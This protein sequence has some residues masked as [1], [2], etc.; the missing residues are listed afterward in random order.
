VIDR[1]TYLLLQDVIRREGRSFLQYAAES[2]PWST[3]EEQSKA[4]Q[5]KQLVSEERESA[6]ALSR[7]LVKH[8]LTP[9]YLGAY[10]S[11]FTSYNYLSLDRLIPLLVEHQK[12]G[13]A[14]L[15]TDLN[16]LHDGETHQQVE[17]IVAMKKRH[18][19]ALEALAK[20]K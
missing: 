4:A 19:Q 10:P 12:H 5:L 15:E 6:T 1:S 16:A 7:Y 17:A 20:S 13:L 8:R 3:P 2:F 9:P 18:L 14:G 11:Y